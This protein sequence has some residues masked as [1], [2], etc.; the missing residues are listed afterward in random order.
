MLRRTRACASR[1]WPK[2]LYSLHGNY[3]RAIHLPNFILLYSLHFFPLL[4]TSTSVASIKLFPLPAF[5]SLAAQLR[6]GQSAASGSAESTRLLYVAFY[7]DL[8]NT[9]D[10]LRPPN[11][12]FFVTKATGETGQFNTRFGSHNKPKRGS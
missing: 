11:S 7:A 1:V 4:P 5:H 3:L 6:F 9:N 10:S 8:S 12:T 2:Y